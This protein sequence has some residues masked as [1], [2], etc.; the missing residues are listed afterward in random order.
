MEEKARMKGFSPEKDE[1]LRCGSRI[2]RIIRDGGIVSPH[3][4]PLPAGEGI[5]R[6]GEVCHEDRRQVAR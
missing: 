4:N 3:P 6:G 5:D 2:E 1:K